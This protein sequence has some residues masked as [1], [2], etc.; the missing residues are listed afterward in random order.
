MTQEL[1]L[2]TNKAMAVHPEEK[3]A[4]AKEWA[5][6]L[7]RT[8]D[9][10]KGFTEMLGN[11]KYLK[12]EAWQLIAA[13]AG[14]SIATTTEPVREKGEIVGYKAIA[15]LVDIQT[16]EDRG[17]AA[18]QQ[19]RM[20]SDVQKG[21]HTVDKKHTAVMGMAQ[22]RASSR[23]VRENYAFVAL[24]GGFQPLTAEE[25]TDD[26]RKNASAD[27]SPLVQHAKKQGATV[28]A[29][30]ITPEEPG[31]NSSLNSTSVVTTVDDSSFSCPIHPNETQSKKTNK[32]GA[33]FWSHQQDGAWCAANDWN[34]LYP[35]EEIA[36]AWSQMLITAIGDDHQL[37]LKCAGQPIGVWLQTVAETLAMDDAVEKC[38]VCGDNAE[39]SAEDGSWYC[40][41]HDPS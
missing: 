30:I 4:Q 1:S 9:S 8:I 28:E 17:A 32:A 23:V 21:Q 38:I 35:R 25:I 10:T 19:C 22:T 18:E 34:E 20:D 14:L 24:L 39:I 5:D 16:G 40:I 33:T 29:V 6:T 7:I 36:D 3:M 37:H 12:V 26:M 2:N 15:K 41:E 27:N 11:N 13:F 31:E